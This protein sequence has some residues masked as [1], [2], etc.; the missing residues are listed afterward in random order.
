MTHLLWPQLLSSS[1]HDHVGYKWLSSTHICLC[2][3]F[4][5]SIQSRTYRAE[6]WHVSRGQGWMISTFCETIVEV[7]GIESVTQSLRRTQTNQ[8]SS[9]L[10]AGWAPF[11]QVDQEAPFFFPTKK[12]AS[13]VERRKTFTEETSVGRSH[14]FGVLSWTKLNRDGDKMVGFAR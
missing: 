8:W 3:G 1:W 2:V 7:N 5:P 11:N 14:R 10:L 13:E 6:L 9:V 4:K 12:T